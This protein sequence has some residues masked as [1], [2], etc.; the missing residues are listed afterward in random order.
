MIRSVGYEG[1][2]SASRGQGFAGFLLFSGSVLPDVY[3]DA[4]RTSYDGV[5]LEM[6]AGL[7][8]GSFRFRADETGSFIE[9]I[10]SEFFF[11]HPS[12]SYISGSGG[13]L[14]ISSSNFFLSSSGD[15]YI[16]G[17]INAVS[18]NIG[19]W[20][21]EPNE[22]AQY[23]PGTGSVRLVGHSTWPV[24]EL[25]LLSGVV[26]SREVDSGYT[27][28]SS[29]PGIATGRNDMG[30][31]YANWRNSGS[32]GGYHNYRIY[33]YRVIFGQRYYSSSYLQINSNSTS[34]SY[35]FY[36]VLSWNA[37]TN[38]DGYRILKNTNDPTIYILKS[39]ENLNAVASDDIDLV[40]GWT[41]NV[42]LTHS[43]RIYP[44][45]NIDGNRYYSGSCAKISV[46][47]VDNGTGWKTYIYLA[48]TPVSQSDGYRIVKNTND[49]TAF[50]G[51]MNWDYYVDTT[52]F[53]YMDMDTTVWNYRSQLFPMYYQ[54][55]RF[56]I[57]TI[58]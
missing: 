44:Y 46:N 19:G 30:N 14:V 38:A 21:I 50:P 15:V 6:H 7:N 1:Y 22:L 55:L 8:S 54:H 26:V 17:T 27:L 23:S 42:L 29:S 51:G 58:M 53:T 5:G 4:K 56:G 49:T 57:M 3:G 34:G 31:Q 25:P 10:T 11:G 39:L 13:I 43:Y 40:N 18:G 41:T 33:P 52:E 36:N 32:G 24:S 48:W 37:S 47:P 35:E 28:G 45:R 9:I 2:G 16:S 20:I 12:S